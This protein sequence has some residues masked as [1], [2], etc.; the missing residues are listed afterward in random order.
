MEVLEVAP[1]GVRLRVRPATPEQAAF[2]RGLGQGWEGETLAFV[3]RHAGPG[4]AFVDVGAWIGPI[5]LL[6]AKRGARVVALEP[7]PAARS[8]LEENLALNGLKAEVLPAALHAD[9]GGLVLY[10]GARGLGASTTSALG[11]HRGDPVQ[12]PTVTAEEV[13]DRA[14]GGARPTALKVDVEGHEY[15]LGPA[16]ARLRALL[17]GAPTH[18][19]LHP[20][21]LAKALRRG[22]P[23]FA[24]RRAA[25]ATATLLAT[26]EGAPIRASGEAAPLDPASLP[27]RCRRNFAVEIG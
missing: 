11:V 4:T 20:R 18:L 1:A 6:A 9:G 26:F 13:A 8:A 21:Q 25:A 12:V 10:G 5:T 24:S 19:S 23:F 14:G 22:S 27:A 16:L 15:A 3:A 17:G 7:D 2:W